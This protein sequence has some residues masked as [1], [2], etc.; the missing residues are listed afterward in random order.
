MRILNH[1]TVLALA[2]LAASA[3]TAPPAKKTTPVNPTKPAAVKPAAAKT[4]A[5][6]P[7]VPTTP[8]KTAATAKAAV[9]PADPNDPVVMTVGDQKITKVEFERFLSAL[10]EQVRAQA[11]GPNKRRFAEQVAEMK[12]L[13]YE[14]R[15]RKLD[16][17]PET[18][19][20][21]GLQ[22]DNVLAS[23]LFRTL[24]AS[25]KTDE[26][27]LKA[28]YDQHKGEYEEVKASHI[29]IRVKGA[30]VPVREGQKELTDEE[31][32]AKVKAL[33]EKIAGGGDF[34]AIAKAESDDTGSGANGGELGSFGH[35]QMV[36]EFDKAAFA[37]PV[38]QV[39]EPVKT[40]FGYHLIK[41]SEHNTKKFEEMKPKIENQLKQEMSRKAI[42]EVKKT[43]PV[44]IDDAYF[45]K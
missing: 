18:Q 34:A 41:V 19:A 36:P 39:S 32:L 44:T 13:A 9:K 31:A 15:L 25:L 21:I 45:G 29:L 2:A 16:Q 11:A 1:T 43:V 23:E 27:S 22:V 6:K 42:D 35:G 26:P 8:A 10:P 4:A 7:A 14:A 20:K 12:S 3:Q 28:Y 24:T 17:D 40:Q 38:G 5:V 30:Q 37:L 33:R